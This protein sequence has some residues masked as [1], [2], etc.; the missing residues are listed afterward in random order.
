MPKFSKAHSKCILGSLLKDS[1]SKKYLLQDVSLCHS[2][3]P[4]SCIVSC[5]PWS[6]GFVGNL[7]YN[8]PCSSNTSRWPPTRIHNTGKVLN[9]ITQLKKIC[10]RATSDKL[11]QYFKILILR[12]F[13]FLRM[14]NCKSFS[15]KRCYFKNNPYSFTLK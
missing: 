9:K 5:V 10:R 2:F 15:G 13:F 6:S 4:V 1:K 12:K 3:W 14:T 11:L 8:R 7:D